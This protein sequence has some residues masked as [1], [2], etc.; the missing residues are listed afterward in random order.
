MI[1]RS[2]SAQLALVILPL[3][4]A[5]WPIKSNRPTAEALIDAGS[6]GIEGVDGRVVAVGDWNGDKK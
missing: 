5:I 6:F 3:V 4:S 1:I 2:R